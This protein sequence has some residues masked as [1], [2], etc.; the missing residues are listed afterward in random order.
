MELRVTI[1]FL[2]RHDHFY[3][4][5]YIFFAVC[6]LTTYVIWVQNVTLGKI[7]GSLLCWNYC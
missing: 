7:L 3:Q 1:V 4:L 2:N 6:I 5:S